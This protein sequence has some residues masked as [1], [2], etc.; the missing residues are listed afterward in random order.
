MVET[1]FSCTAGSWRVAA[2]PCGIH[3]PLPTMMV[4]EGTRYAVGNRP[5]LLKSKDYRGGIKG[6]S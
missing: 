5:Y 3:K 1:F 2:F 6:F 4:V